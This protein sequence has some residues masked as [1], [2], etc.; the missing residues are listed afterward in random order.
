MIK[1]SILFIMMIVLVVLTSCNEGKSTQIEI[2]RFPITTIGTK[3][4][5]ITNISISP[6]I[7][8][9]ASFQKNYFDLWNSYIKEKF[10][11]ELKLTEIQRSTV[12]DAG[13]NIKDM[14]ESGQLTGFV[15]IP[16]KG[17]N[18]IYDLIKSE[19]II[20]LDSTLSANKYWAM[21]PDDMKNIAN[22]SG[23]IWGIPDQLNPFYYIR[24]YKKDWL[25]NADI[26]TPYDVNSFY[27]ALQYFTESDPDNDGIDN[28]KGT[29]LRT[30]NLIDLFCEFGY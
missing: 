1:K 5:D 22:I 23:S 10:N 11:I 6:M 21:L 18:V 25:A 16:S 4:Q 30:D 24:S 7:Y 14:I 28:T 9:E 2:T 29:Y 27:T 13:R 15:Y 26:D 12:Y 19:T 17:Y 3:P 8:S 20:P